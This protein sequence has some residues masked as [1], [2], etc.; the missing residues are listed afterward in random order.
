MSLTYRSGVKIR[1]GEKLSKTELR[2]SNGTLANMKIAL[3][4]AV[5]ATQA[6]S[7]A[8]VDKMAEAVE[9]QQKAERARE[10]DA[11]M[12]QTER[13]ELQQRIFEL[14]SRLER[15]QLECRIEIDGGCCL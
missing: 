7:Q 14:T 6:M 13:D 11:K 12:Y 8:T 9:A 3:D 15:D 1:F 10:R 4:D 2:T 5:R